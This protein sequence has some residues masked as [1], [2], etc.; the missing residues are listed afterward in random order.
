[1]TGPTIEN[2]EVWRAAQ[3]IMEHHPEEPELAACQLADAALD[4]GD[5]FGFALWQKVAKT[6]AKLDRS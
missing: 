3:R 6:V 2:L 5:V 4:K 1:M